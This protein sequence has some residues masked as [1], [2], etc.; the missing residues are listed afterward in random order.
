MLSALDL[1]HRI[2]AGEL[3]PRA[4]IDMCAEAIAARE[5]DV[6]AFVVLD[7]DGARRAADNPKLAATP[8]RGLPVG[9]KDIFDTADFPTQYGSP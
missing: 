2:E 4:V 9:F 5:K 1:A 7:L 8:L 3:T 6:G